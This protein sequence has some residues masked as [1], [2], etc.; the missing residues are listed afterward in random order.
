MKKR[1]LILAA[2]LP[3]L[4]ACVYDFEAELTGD[5][6][7]V[8][9]EGDILIGGTTTL[10]FSRLNPEVMQSESADLSSWLSSSWDPSSSYY[11]PPSWNIPVD[12]TATVE[13]EDGSVVQAKGVSGFCSL[14]T[15]NLD[16]NVRYRL[17][18][19]DERNGDQYSTPWQEVMAAPVVDSL[20]YNNKESS[21]DIQIT[22]H[23]DGST[24]Y[25]CLVYD[26]QWEYHA[27]TTTYMRYIPQ[28]AAEPEKGYVVFPDPETGWGDRYGRIFEVN[29]PYPNYTC[30]DKSISG[31]SSVVTTGAMVSNKL[32]DYV[33]KTLLPDDRKTSVAYRP[34]VSMRMISK[35]SFAYWES[36]DKASSQTGD[37]FS[38]IP[39][40]LRGNL[41]NED[42]P[43]AHVIGYVGVSQQ[44]VADRLIK[45]SEIEFYRQPSEISEMLR[46]ASI[47]WGAAGGVS[48]V[49]MK[50]QYSLGNRPWRL[51]L[52]DTDQEDA[53]AF[54]VWI[55][56]YCMDC[57]KQGGT[58]TKPADWPE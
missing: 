28:G 19:L 49:Q 16:P 37:L 41:T 46:K 23:S 13:G 56:E 58:T 1:W 15:R 48:A 4:G 27:Y 55:P 10:R 26:E 8:V 38:P 44:V 18:L 29:E 22:F 7:T 25:Y 33:V 11:N 31:V 40:L 21:L 14:D 17:L 42:N 5:E 47:G 43:D 12:F 57:R 39:S 50:S 35:E 2:L 36:L 52:P 6:Y 3:L 30:W 34:I 53:E 45:A 20:S 9:V 51:E 24:P 32:V 54:Y